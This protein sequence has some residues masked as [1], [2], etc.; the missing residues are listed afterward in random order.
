MKRM[1]TTIIISVIALAVGG[2]FFFR[3]N[4]KPTNTSADKKPFLN[5][6]EAENIVKQLVDLGYYKYAAP[7]DIDSLKED[8]T[9]TIAQYG[10]L[11]TL[12]FDEPLTPKDYRYYM[13]DGETVFE[14]GGF[15]DALKDMKGLFDKIGLKFEITNHI[16]D[17]DT[18]TK[19]LNHEL[20]VNGKRYVIFKDFKD[21]GWGEAAQKFAE[22]V[23]DQ[24]Q[25]QRKDERLY[26]INGGNDGA[27]VY[28]TDKQFDLLDK[29]FTDDQWKPLKVDKWCKVFKVEP[30][31][32]N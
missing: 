23:N 2:L 18:L 32:N 12:Y 11:S 19:G 3:C 7:T 5:R 27:A 21:Y 10:I 29:V 20:T 6:Q 25:I 30:M 13:F 8:L 28:L 24:M 1:T 26:L 14:Q 17:V 22:M 9:S 16:E 15:D 4:S 31:S